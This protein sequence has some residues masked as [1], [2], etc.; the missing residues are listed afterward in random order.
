[1]CESSN[2]MRWLPLALT[3][4]FVCVCVCLSV[5]I[6]AFSPLADKHIMSQR[7]PFR[8]SFA[9]RESVLKHWHKE[10]TKWKRST[11]MANSIIWSE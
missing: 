10:I 8:D 11:E 6:T 3:F 9:N 2:E 4:T 7:S 5:V 1:M